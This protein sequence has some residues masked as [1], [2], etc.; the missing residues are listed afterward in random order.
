MQENK[1]VI[2]ARDDNVMLLTLNRPEALN[3]LSPGVLKGLLEGIAQAD[4]DPDVRALVITGAGKAFCAGGDV[5]GFVRKAEAGERPVWFPAS[6][7]E[8]Y[9]KALRAFGKPALAAINGAAT[10][11]G[12]QMALGCDI[13]IASE[14]ARLGALWVKRGLDAAGYAAYLLPREIGLSNAFYMLYTGD[15]IEA[16][17]AYRMGLVTKVV[18]HD[19]VVSATMELAQRIA[20]NPPLALSM[21]R[22]LVYRALDTPYETVAEWQHAHRQIAFHTEDHLEGSRAFVEKRAPVYKGR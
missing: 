7:E 4:D 15:L 18:P 14:R 12:L 13:R 8:T 1:Q 21:N 2:V 3:A 9:S 10:G 17:E 5:K 6:R 19:K 11:A 20:K 22:R 16:E